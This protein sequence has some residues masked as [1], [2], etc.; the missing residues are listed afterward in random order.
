MQRDQP[1]QMTCSL[2]RAEVTAIRER[3]QDVALK[4]SLQFGIRP[5]ERAKMAYPVRVVRDVHE[6]INDLAFR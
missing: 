6:N 2:G 3:R 1:A 4:G 5:R